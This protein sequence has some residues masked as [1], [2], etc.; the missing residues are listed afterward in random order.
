MHAVPDA[1]AVVHAGPAVVA[2]VLLKFAAPALQQRVPAA[3]FV[4]ASANGA[5][6][7]PKRR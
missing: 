7:Q 2:A 6:V 1:V 3:T 4:G 5:S